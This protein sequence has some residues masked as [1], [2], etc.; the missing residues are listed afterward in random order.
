MPL[1]LGI[2]VVR[3]LPF[4]LN[5]CYPLT[6]FPDSASPARLPALDALSATVHAQG[7]K[8]HS[9]PFSAPL[10][11]LLQLSLFCCSAGLLVCLLP[12]R[13]QLAA[14]DTLFAKVDAQRLQLPSRPSLPHLF[15]I[16][17]SSLCCPSLPNHHSQARVAALGAHRL[18]RHKQGQVFPVA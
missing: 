5:P 16:I 4:L 18:K 11:S 1:L 6:P 12:P 2:A 15:I 14:L 13:A 17:P 9:R 8:L 10:S 7:L 3:M